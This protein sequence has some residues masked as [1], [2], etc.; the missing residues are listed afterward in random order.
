MVNVLKLEVLKTNIERLRL[1]AIQEEWYAIFE[2]EFEGEDFKEE[3]G[4]SQEEAFLSSID[5]WSS[6]MEQNVWNEIVKDWGENYIIDIWLND[7]TETSQ[8]K[9]KIRN[10]EKECKLQKSL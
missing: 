5:Y 7:N 8:L 10:F 4:V 9:S 1:L 6:M 3:N 2:G